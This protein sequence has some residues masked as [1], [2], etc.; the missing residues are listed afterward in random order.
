MIVVVVIVVVVIVVVVIVVVVD[1]A[2][3]KGATRINHSSSQLCLLA[4]KNAYERN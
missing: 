2:V 1:G 4:A 3:I